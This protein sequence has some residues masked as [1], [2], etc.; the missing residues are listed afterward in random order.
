MKVAPLW[1]TDFPLVEWDEESERFHAMHHPFTSPKSEDI[2]KM[3]T[4][5]G[6][7]RA[8]ANDLVI[9]GVEAG[10]VVLVFTIAT[11]R[12]KCSNFWASHPKKQ[13]LNLVFYW[14][15]LSMEHRLMV[16]LLWALIGFAQSCQV[17]RVFE[18]L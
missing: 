7:V 1:V 9:N 6:S 4:D 11:C 2:E 18:I 5:P 12:L 3:E 14:T 13:K 10:G 15:L 16:G 17:K 8:N